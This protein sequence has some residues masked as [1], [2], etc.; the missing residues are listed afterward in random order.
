MRNFNF[1]FGV[2]R[3]SS[4]VLVLGVSHS[5]FSLSVFG[6]ALKIILDALVYKDM[7]WYGHNRSLS[8]ADW[9]SDQQWV[10][11]FFFESTDSSLFF[12]KAKPAFLPKTT[13]LFLNFVRFW[14]VV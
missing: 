6:L 2:V 9:L 13:I 1:T 11:A 14:A 7:R 5:P 8:H 4:L 3:L 10:M 12:V